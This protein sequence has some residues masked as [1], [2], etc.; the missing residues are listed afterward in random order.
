MPI[1]A[2][3]KHFLRKNRNLSDGGSA[4]DGLPLEKAEARL[5]RARQLL[6]SSGHLD[7]YDWPLVV[8]LIVE[9]QELLAQAG[10]RTRLLDEVLDELRLE[11]SNF[12][13]P[14]FLR[15]TRAA[16]R[17]APSLFMPLASRKEL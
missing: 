9:A 6:N 5:Q 14:I 4:A 11:T 12:S 1:S 3:R 15:S 10:K 8:S 13:N 7:S 16:R 2:R 17:H